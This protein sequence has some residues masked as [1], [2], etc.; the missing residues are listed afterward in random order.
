MQ[1]EAETRRAWLTKGKRTVLKVQ[2]GGKKQSYIGFLQKA[3]GVCTVEE[4]AW[5]NTETIL[6]TLHKL[7][8][9]NPGKKVVILWD[10]AA[11]HRSQELRSHLGEGN[12]L[13]RLHLIWFPPYAPDHNPIEHVWNAAKANAANM[14]EVKFEDTKKKFVDYISNRTFA[15]EL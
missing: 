3:T 14:Q 4:L 8:D 1:E 10:N 15:Y 5:Q 7:L 13:E 12:S 9:A 6:P 11:W 2:R